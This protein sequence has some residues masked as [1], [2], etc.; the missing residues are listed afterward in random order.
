MIIHRVTIF[1]PLMLNTTKQTLVGLMIYHRKILV[2]NKNKARKCELCITMLIKNH[3]F[4]FPTTL[5]SSPLSEWK[6]I[7]NK[8][9]LITIYSISLIIGNIINLIFNNIKW[10]NPCKTGNIRKTEVLSRDSYYEYIIKKSSLL[11]F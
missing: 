7:G 8:K 6:G 9:K 5:L 10:N 11:T 4:E 2:N 1:V 3:L